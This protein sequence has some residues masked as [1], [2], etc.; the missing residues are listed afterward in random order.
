MNSLSTNSTFLF[1]NGSLW[2]GGK[3]K[4]KRG[5]GA[6]RI[7]NE[8]GSRQTEKLLSLHLYPK[9]PVLK[10]NQA[11]PRTRATTAQK[12][13]AYVLIPLIDWTS[14]PPSP[15]FGVITYLVTSLP[16]PVPV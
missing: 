4:K 6:I 1:Q 3:E 12:C 10:S 8:R 7:T 15:R 2:I 5:K 16:L 11:S 13:D 14:G 9:T